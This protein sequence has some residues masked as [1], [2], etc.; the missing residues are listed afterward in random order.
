M[1]NLFNLSKIE[2]NFQDLLVDLKEGIKLSE[3]ANEEKLKI[4][5]EKRLYHFLKLHGIDLSSISEYEAGSIGTI[6]I[7]G[8]TD[9]LYGSLILEFKKY[10]LLSTEAGFKEAL[11]QVNKKYLSA[12]PE[13]KRASFC[14]IIFDGVKLIFIKWDQKVLGWDHKIKEFNENSL[15]DWI[16]TLSGARKKQ[17]SASILRKDFAIDKD[18]AVN[19]ISTF[20]DKLIHNLN[21]G[22]ERVSMLFNEWDKTFRY[23]Y[24]G[25]LDEKRIKQD[26]DE[27]T[28]KILKKD[29]A[30]LVDK[31]LFVLYTYYAF[32][33][34]LFASEIACISLK[35]Y[36]ESPIGSLLRSKN[37]KEDLEYIESGKFFRDF[38][39]VENYIEGGFFSWYLAIWDND[40]KKEIEN[41]LKSVNEYDPQS[42]FMDEHI[43]RDLLKNLYQDIVP[44][45]IRHDL[46]EFYT[47]DWLIQL[48]TAES[49]F[50]GKPK[51]KILDPG[52]GSGGFL[53]EFIN[54]MKYSNFKSTKKLN[55]S[56]LLAVICNN[57]IGFDVNPVAIL[58]A[59]TN[60]LLSI[61]SLLSERESKTI[62][63]PV[64]LADSIITP[65]TEGKGWF[66]EDRYKISTVE[67][68]FSL[69]RRIVD[70]NLLDSV[71]KVIEQ[72]VEYHYPEKDFLALLNKEIPS[73]TEEE[74]KEVVEFYGRLVQLH[75]DHKNEIWVKIIQ[76]S[77]APLL[78]KNFDYVVGN[79]PWIKW[80]FLS[81]DYKK[82]L[83]ILYLDIYKLF[84]HKGM[85]AG[86]G[87]AHDDISIVF[88]YVA[89]DKY[90]KNKGI[91]T[92]VLKQTLYKSIA[93]KEFRKFAIEKKSGTIPVK[94]LKVHD[95]VNLNP[96]GQGQETSVATLKKKTK[97]LY[98]V[99][100]L[101]WGKKE[102]GRFEDITP[103][104]D[105]KSK[106]NVSEFDAYPDPT[107]GDITDVWILMPKGQAIPK[108]KNVPNF[109][110]ARH[111][112][113]NDLN[114]VFFLK[115]NKKLP[116]GLLS[117]SNRHNFGKKKTKPITMDI[118]P[119]LIYPNIKPGNTDK[120]GING[121][122]YMIVTQQ[123]A[124]EN[125]ESE[126]RT[127]TPE[128]YAYLF[129]FK[130][131]LLERKSKWF[132]GSKKP[133][134]S[135]F[136]IGPY[137]FQKYKVVWLCMSY[138]PVFSVVSKVDDEF[139]GKKEYIPDNTI[140]YIS[141]DSEDEAHFVCA[142]LNSSIAR[143]LFAM[144]SSKS[145]WGISISM[146]NKIPIPEFDREDKNHLK[147][148]KLSKKAHL[149]KSQGKLQEIKGI[150]EQINEIISNN[151]II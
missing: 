75:K 62:T 58:T 130:K 115:I 73:L 3:F 124:G 132:K 108:I 117:V 146:V 77:F 116:N 12:I 9:A 13:S 41:V 32:I 96:F 147:L 60:Y 8:R 56:Q 107:K 54:R 26:F 92:F 78:Y 85:E 95:L 91:L 105:V 37:L 125:N 150:E 33:V 7:K 79:P 34:K 87:F 90:L 15:Y 106:S 134:Y 6:K 14:A 121:C 47:P 122:Q 24:G 16:L 52:C 22:H 141:L 50:K 43:S 4:E 109:Y 101:K 74:V 63:L 89:M 76:N 103:L 36:P 5:T 138:K 86:L 149:L 118:E 70:D 102:K 110:Y 143:S 61:S 29:S 45:G 23:I 148:S 127:K 97:N 66:Q 137:T 140:G 67:G 71:L 151:K 119:D 53:V 10:N 25:I 112:V 133:F 145:K 21:N 123:K 111:G 2:E 27:I 136:G 126:I 49:G 144:R 38:A 131:Q 57:V 65:T 83:G 93:G 94:V 30:I 129:T 55:P 51:E 42:F 88:T 80:D 59:R 44:N 64:F 46:G 68:E 120:W 39:G 20:Y 139:I 48:A 17:V 104:D 142:I 35:I 114:S 82:K 99:P 135:L 18:V 84:S 40:I 98:P 100:Y 1:V 69:P 28:K 19:F 31:F 128:T 11:K 113:V 72:T 81:E